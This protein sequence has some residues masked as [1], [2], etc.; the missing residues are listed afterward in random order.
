MD[1]KTLKKYVIFGKGKNLDEQTVLSIIDNFEQFDEDKSGELSSDELVKLMKEYFRLHFKVRLDLVERITKMKL[2]SV[3]KD[4]SGAINL[5]E[6]FDL[7]VGVLEQIPPAQRIPISSSTSDS[8]PIQVI[9]SRSIGFSE[10]EDKTQED[11]V[12]SKLTEF[13]SNLEV[14]EDNE[15]EKYR[16]EKRNLIENKEDHQ[17]K[18]NV[19]NGLTRVSFNLHYDTVFGENIFVVGEGPELGD[20]TPQQGLRMAWW[21][22]NHWSIDTELPIGK[23]IQFKYAVIELEEGPWYV[24][25]WEDSSPRLIAVNSSPLIVNSPWNF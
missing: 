5:D 13:D 6:F 12:T 18:T 1:A 7:F 17:Q 10:S 3:D 22:G 9:T 2:Q 4:K 14:E 25:R 8:Q 20:W 16:N 23:D 11:S 24:K 19:N 15:T 21:P